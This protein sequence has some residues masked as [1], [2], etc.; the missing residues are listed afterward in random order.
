MLVLEPAS[1]RRGTATNLTAGHRGRPPVLETLAQRLWLRTRGR[2]S[3]GRSDRQ[4][5]IDDEREL[6]AVPL[7]ADEAM[8]GAR[9]PPVLRRR[10]RPPGKDDGAVHHFQANPVAESPGVILVIKAKNTDEITLITAEKSEKGGGVK[11]GRKINKSTP[12]PKVHKSVCKLEA[13]QQY[14]H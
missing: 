2:R 10:K 6:D 14:D 5:A 11:G 13:R 7:G 8:T 9:V 3:Q 4:A 1:W 12:N